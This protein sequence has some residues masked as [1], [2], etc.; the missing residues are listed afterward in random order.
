MADSTDRKDSSVKLC[1]SRK[2]LDYKKEK[3]EE[4]KDLARSIGV[5]CSG[6]EE[7]MVAK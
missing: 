1:G 2:Q 5:D 7:E 4:N 3:Y 6:I